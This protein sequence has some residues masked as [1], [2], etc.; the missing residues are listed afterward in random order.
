MLGAL[1][2]VGPWLGLEQPSSKMA[3]QNA[4]RIV[5]TSNPR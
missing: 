4:H 5:Y 3:K 2:T 1:E